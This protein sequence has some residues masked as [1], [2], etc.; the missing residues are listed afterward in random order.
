[1]NSRDK[2]EKPKKKATIYDIAMMAGTSAATVSRVLNNGSYPI[3]KE[4][5]KKVL[6]AA[7][8]LRYSPNLLGRMLK[9]SLS[10]E[11]G[12]IIPNISNPFYPQLVLGIEM[13]AKIHGFNILLCNSFRDVS[14]EKKYIESMYQ[15]QIKG[16]ILSTIREEHGFLKELCENGLKIV[17]FDQNIEDFRCNKVSFDFTAGAIMAIDYLVSMGHKKIAF[18]TSPLVRRSRKEIFNG[19][20]LG[21]M[22]NDMA[23]SDALVHIMD[24]EKEVENGTFEFESG[25]NLAKDILS[26][27][28][29]PTAIFAV[30]DITAMGII[31]GLM[32]SKVKVP[33][34]IS[35]MGFD[36]IEFSAMVN[37]PL[38]TIN[39]PA[40]E[41]GRLACRIL[42]QNLEKDEEGSVSFKLEPT[43]VVRDSVRDIRG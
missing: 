26:S 39:Q 4:I 14:N 20:K 43:L 33:E 7:Q 31:H 6:D 25:K 28:E 12:V 29:L 38:T 5:R 11:I 15:K 17:G 8:K 34:D 3:S 2:Q 27:K 1:M 42:I 21:L 23:F 40:F 18:A 35:V 9:K 13:E 10:K 16:I 30:N 19:Y 32:S 22:K 36:N 37:P 41:T 24:V